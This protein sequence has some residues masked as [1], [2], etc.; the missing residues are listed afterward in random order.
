MR[1]DDAIISIAYFSIPVQLVFSLYRYPRLASMPLRILILCILF[2]LFIFLCG[3]GH[4]MRC[5]DHAYGT[6]FLILNIMTSF[7]SLVTALYLLPLVPSLFSD[8]DSSLQD[9]VNLNKETAESKRKLFTFMA[10]LCH[11]IRN[12]LFAITTNVEFAQDLEMSADLETALNSIHQSTAL[13]LRLVNDVLDLSKI[14]SGKL[15]LEEQEFDV[16]DFF[17][18]VASSMKRQVRHKRRGN[19]KFVYNIEQSV[20]RIV[21]CDSVRVLQTT[22]NLLSNAVKFTSEGSI[23]LSISVCDLADAVKNG[24][25]KGS[26]DTCTKGNASQEECDCAGEH[27]QPEDFSMSLLQAAEEGNC[28]SSVVSS[29]DAGV[30]VL[31]IVVEDTGVG[32]PMEKRESI[33]QAYTQSKLSDYRKHGGTGLGLPIISNLTD[34]MG[35]TIKVETQE[36]TG[37]KFI[38]HIPVVVPTFQGKPKRRGSFATTGALLELNGEVSTDDDSSDSDSETSCSSS[39]ALDASIPDDT[40]TI[41]MVDTLANTKPAS[42]FALDTPMHG[43]A[44]TRLFDLT[45]VPPSSPS[46]NILGSTSCTAA[47]TSTGET[48]TSSSSASAESAANTND[49]STF[50]KTSNALAPLLAVPMKTSQAPPL[51]PQPLFGTSMPAP[52]AK[53]PKPQPLFGASVPAPNTEVPK[54]QPLFGAS[55]PA[56]NTEVPKPQPLFGAS[57]PAPNSEVPKPQPLFGASMPATQTEAPTVAP[58][59]STSA[60]RKAKK[61]QLSKFNFKQNERKVLVVDDNSLNRKLLGKMLSFF[62]LEY[63]QAEHGQMAVDIIAKSRNVTGDPN[64]P[65][66][67]LVLMDLCMPVMD[68]IEAIATLRKRGL[69]LPIIALTANALEEGKTSALDAGATDYA[70]KPI[71]RSDLHAK[72]KEFLEGAV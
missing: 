22:Y 16:H 7:I 39:S 69:Q 49:S 27:E 6:S 15:E 56:P 53:V 41:P 36:G 68:G 26:F 31:R 32:I 42:L 33:F 70:T 50:S 61:P 18:N 67:G 30:Q 25:V 57:V 17:Q 2:A 48:T 65:E 51:K 54:P 12:P 20:P 8:L 35:G 19:V 64:A 28:Y 13:M 11:E 9:L 40:T 23:N 45:S 58:T 59:S 29:A 66:F 4:L 55:M 14:E 60:P 47:T 37:S 21:R 46:T 71:L 24:L 44:S 38:V 1:L 43:P 3:A 10:F 5:M 62:N 34:I 72:C 52:P 63:E